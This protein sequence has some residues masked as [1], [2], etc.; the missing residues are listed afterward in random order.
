M[1]IKTAVWISNE[2][3]KAIAETKMRKEL[4][5]TFEFVEDNDDITMHRYRYMNKELENQK[6]L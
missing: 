1:A 3:R 4:V 2:R 6:T 5:R